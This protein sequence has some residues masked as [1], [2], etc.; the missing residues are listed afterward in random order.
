MLFNVAL[1]LLIIEDVCSEPY[2][3]QLNSQGNW[4]FR[5]TTPWAPPAVILFVLSGG[6]RFR[7]S[8][9]KFKPHQVF[10]K[11]Y[12]EASLSILYPLH[13]Q[14]AQ[15]IS[16]FE[17]SPPPSSL[18][19]GT[20]LCWRSNLLEHEAPQFTGIY[21]YLDCLK[22]VIEIWRG[23]TPRVLREAFSSD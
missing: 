12:L 23:E 21:S 22:L 10:R 14:Q 16:Q 7:N 13:S 20:V 1:S 15:F 11:L 2:S 6:V 3:D 4:P 9:E 18:G 8:P 17:I 19:K 5:S